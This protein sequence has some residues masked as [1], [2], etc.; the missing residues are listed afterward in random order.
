MLSNQLPHTWQLI[1]THNY[2]LTDFLAQKFGYSAMRHPMHR[3]SK[4]GGAVISFGVLDPK[5]S[6]SRLT[7][8]G[9]IQFL[10]IAGLRL[11]ATGSFPGLLA[12]WPSQYKNL[13]LQGQ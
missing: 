6:S 1:T 11:S 8:V 2:Y 3:A 13:L 4:L 5:M 12:I 9:W 7:G 10:A